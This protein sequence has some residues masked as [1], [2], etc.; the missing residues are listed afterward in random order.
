MADM[1]YQIKVT[2]PVEITLTQ[3]EREEALAYGIERGMLHREDIDKGYDRLDYDVVF[4]RAVMGL[5]EEGDKFRYMGDEGKDAVSDWLHENDG[6]DVV[7]CAD[8]V[9]AYEVED[10]EDN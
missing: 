4:E 8:D 6:A 1:V 2:I 3:E 5:H 7:G 9:V 10:E